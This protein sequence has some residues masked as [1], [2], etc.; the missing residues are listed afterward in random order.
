MAE[1]TVGAPGGGASASTGGEGGGSSAPVS[2]PSTST[3]APASSTAPAA[4]QPQADSAAPSQ[5]DSAMPT[6]K[7]GETDLAYV[8][9]YQK[10]NDEQKLKAAGDKTTQPAKPAEA[11]APVAAAKPA[12]SAKPAEP[13]KPAEAAKPE[14]EAEKNPLDDIGPLPASKVAEALKANPALEAEL[15]KAGIGKE[16]LFSSLREAATATQFR[17]LFNDVETAQFA[18][19]AAETFQRMDLAA[20]ELK[21]GD[22]QS[23]QKFIQE[24]LMPMSYLLDEQGKPKMREVKGRD[25]QTYQIPE[26]DGTVNTFL[27]NVLMH[28]LEQ[29]EYQCQGLLQQNNEFAKER[30]ERVMA[31]IHELRDFAEGKGGNEN[32]SEEVKAERARLDADRAAFTE[33]KRKEADERFETFRQDV[34]G[35]TNSF[36]DGAVNDFLSK[37]SLA[38]DP[39]DSPQAKESKKFV[40]DGVLR[41]IRDGLFARF[42]S[43][44][45][46][47]AEMEQIGRRGQSAVVKQQLVNL[48]KRQTNAVI[49]KV[50]DPILKKAG[51]LRVE[52]SKTRAAKIATQIDNSRT[53]PRGS[54]S[55]AIP[56][57]PKVDDAALTRQAY[58]EL[59]A[60][61]RRMPNP[62]EIMERA[63]ALKAAAM[64]A[65]TA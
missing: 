27:D 10:W 20:T 6:R 7:V 58:A 55:A 17:E 12:E 60:E 28:G 42:N 50:A 21:P 36:V 48:Y 37:T 57:T 41:E 5:A 1:E 45:L 19:Q 53:E 25:G 49:E 2:A 14:G 51:A 62:T 4:G 26:T 40:R 33:T 46:F 56:T 43:N 52:A 18:R 8:E 15:E 9:R 65:A 31:A 22:L 24:V 16:E 59:V 34:L 13:A 39:N 63:R 30:A 47:I 29:F 11:P 3:A 38:D 44:P 32:L 23:T 61:K 35:S 64:K 54:T